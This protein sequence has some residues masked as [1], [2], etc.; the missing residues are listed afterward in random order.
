MALVHKL[1]VKGR[2]ISISN[3]RFVQGGINSDT[4]S[5]ELDPEFA[6]CERVLVSL[7]R[8]DSEND[9]LAFEL[10]ESKTVMVPSDILATVGTFA[11]GVT[12]YDSNGNARITT[13]AM[14]PG[15]EC[16]VVEASFIINAEN[17]PSEEQKDIFQ[18]LAEYV[19][20]IGSASMD[21]GT[22]DTLE[23]GQPATA[24]FTG[25]GLQKILNLGLPKGAAG[26]KGDKGDPGE[27]G[28][29]G[30]DGKDGQDGTRGPQGPSGPKGDTGNP[31]AQ[32][33][34]GPKG[35]KGDPGEAP[36]ISGLLPLTGGTLTGSLSV[37]EI[38][39]ADISDLETGPDDLAV[40][41]ATMKAYCATL[42]AKITNLEMIINKFLKE[43]ESE[44]PA[45]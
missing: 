3:K 21:I 35:D 2:K 8:D 29:N 5:I 14:G 40:N 27:P 18:Q 12:G 10:N 38:H 41:L 19:A 44:P 16:E 7:K 6:E 17:P 9:P 22:V 34:A 4:L 37:D 23:S 42:E 26:P 39:L 45:S 32:G 30:A 43:K 31:G 25:E 24:S 1:S 11:I 15:K 33:P 28:K 13:E 36:D 20:Q